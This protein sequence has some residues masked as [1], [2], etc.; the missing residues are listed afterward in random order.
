MTQETISAIRAEIL[1]Q[2]LG[3]FE[4]T[5][6]RVDLH[7]KVTDRLRFDVAQFMSKTY[8]PINS[9]LQSCSDSGVK[10]SAKLMRFQSYEERNSKSNLCEEETNSSTP[11]ETSPIHRPISPVQHDSVDTKLNEVAATGHKL[12]HTKQLRNKKIKEGKSGTSVKL[13]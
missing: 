3:Y 4:S 12:K 10:S 11:I 9:N 2:F 5:G 8:T 6:E 7:M 1:K 13:Q